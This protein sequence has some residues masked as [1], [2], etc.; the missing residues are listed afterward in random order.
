MK[1]KYNMK[2]DIMDNKNTKAPSRFPQEMPADS[3]KQYDH[4]TIENVV[5]NEIDI[6]PA[7]NPAKPH[8]T[9]SLNTEFAKQ[10]QN[11]M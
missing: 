2:G 6:K 9:D 11:N 3:K 10:A 1:T 8:S 4:G 7:T 5:R